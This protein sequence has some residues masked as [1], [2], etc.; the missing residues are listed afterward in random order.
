[1]YAGVT[2]EAIMTSAPKQ[3]PLYPFLSQPP[4]QKKRPTQP[5]PSPPTQVST[6]PER[7]LPGRRRSAT[8][9]A[10]TAWCADVHPGSPAP[11]SPR[12]SPCGVRR[13]SGSRLGSR[14][15]SISSGHVASGSYFAITPSADDFKDHDFAA[16]GYTSVFVRFPGTPVTPELR[17]SAASSLPVSPAKRGLKQSKSLTS[18]KPAKRSRSRA[19]P[20][21]PFNPSRT[22]AEFK[23]SRALSNAAIAKSKKSKYAKLRPAP[24]A[25]SL[26]LAQFLDGGSMEHHI[27][28]YAY[29]QAKTAGAVKVDGQL[30][31]VGDIWRDEAGGVWRD[32]DEEWEFAHL[33]GDIDDTVDWVSFGS[34]KPAMGEERRGSLSTQDSDLSPRYAMHTDTDVHDDLA[35]FGQV[36]LSPAPIKPGMSV[37]AIPARNRRAAKH[38]RKPEFLLNAFPVPSSPT[39][40]HA[41]HSPR[42]AAHHTGGVRPKGKARRRPAPLKLVPQSPARKLATN[43]EADADQLREEFLMDSFR[44]RP[45]LGRSGQ[46]S[47]VAALPQG[48]VYAV[49]RQILVKPSVM[50]MKGFLRATLGTRKVCAA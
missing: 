31:G 9:S 39:G 12:R 50:N 42:P 15:P 47:R 29:N 36:L 26:A 18:L 19:P 21:P 11:Y 28:H 30:V 3:A 1:M 37:L 16:L 38:L 8:I 4:P 48:A 45:R 14:R 22:S 44:P 35:A 40:P 6:S 20:S 23:R 41:Q 49:P 27:K 43:S 13:S 10:I 7:P 24:L 2:Q 5:L 25:N 32:Q 46:V 34:P 33:L 17:R